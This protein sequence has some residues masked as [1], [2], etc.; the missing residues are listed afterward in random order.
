MQTKD[1]QILTIFRRFLLKE[2]FMSQLTI[3]DLNFCDNLLPRNSEVQ[4]GED[5]LVL[6]FQ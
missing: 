5:T 1:F 4:G 3:F 2:G 6:Y